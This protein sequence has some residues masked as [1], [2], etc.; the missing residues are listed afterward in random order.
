MA[1]CTSAACSA[2]TTE[3]KDIAEISATAVTLKAAV[4]KAAGSL[5]ISLIWGEEIGMSRT[6]EPQMNITRL[7]Y[8]LGGCTRNKDVL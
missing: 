6:L 3:Q 4:A 8:F 1:A 5:L 2:T 7:I